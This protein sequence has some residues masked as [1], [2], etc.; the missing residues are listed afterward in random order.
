[1]R[2]QRNFR[3]WLGT[4]GLHRPLQRSE[5]LTEYER[6]C[7]NAKYLLFEIQ[8]ESGVLVWPTRWEDANV[9]PDRQIPGVVMAS[10]LLT[11]CCSGV[12]CIEQAQVPHKVTKR[13]TVLKVN[14]TIIADETHDFPL[15]LLHTITSRRMIY[16]KVCPS[17]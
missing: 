7:K 12:T 11:A 3:E 8:L 14:G 10:T 4:D 9:F 5:D 16:A 2:C 1:M 15:A 6:A 17:N 13:F